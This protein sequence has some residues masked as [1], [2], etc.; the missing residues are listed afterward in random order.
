MVITN[1]RTRIGRLRRRVLAV[2]CTALAV[3]PCMTM[4]GG[5]AAQAAPVCSNGITPYGDIGAAW[6]RAGGANSV[7]G[8][9]KNREYG[10]GQWRR[11]DFGNG[12]IAWSP[13]Q[14][15]HMIVTAFSSRGQ[16]YFTWGPTNPYRYDK[17]LVRWTTNGDYSQTVQHEL[18]GSRTGG[19]DSVPPSGTSNIEYEIIVE[20]CDNGFWGSTC[21]QSW[22]VPVAVSLGERGLR[23]RR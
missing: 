21:R 11:Q 19:I 9:P 22:T 4:L 17:F 18:T 15:D 1:T 10:P 6:Y 2:L 7:Y 13:A 5:G 3:I 14:G 12:Q 20:G 16:A 8:C 23:V